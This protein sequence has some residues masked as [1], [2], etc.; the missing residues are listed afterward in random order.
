MFV[1]IEQADL[2]SGTYQESNCDEHKF[3]SYVAMATVAFQ[4]SG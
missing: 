1:A 4:N 3:V 2:N